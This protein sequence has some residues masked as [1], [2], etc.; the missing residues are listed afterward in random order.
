MTDRVFLSMCKTSQCYFS[1]LLSVCTDKGNK[2]AKIAAYFSRKRPIKGCYQQCLSTQRCL[3]ITWG[4][5]KKADSDSARL[6][7]NLGLCIS[8]KL[9]AGANG[10]A[11]QTHVQRQSLRRR[12]YPSWQIRTTWKLVENTDSWALPQLH[13]FRISGEGQ[14]LQLIGQFSSFPCIFFLYLFIYL[15]VSLLSCNTQALRC[16]LQDLSLQQMDSLDVMHG[17]Q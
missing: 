7:W 1:L 17:L 10:T 13:W 2:M 16:M 5:C 15:A 12:F 3:W 6:G 14:K 8:D 11:L 9:P 4:C